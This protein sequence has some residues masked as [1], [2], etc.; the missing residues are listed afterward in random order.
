M[1][2]LAVLAVTAFAFPLAVQVVGMPRGLGALLPLVA[3]LGWR[4]GGRLLPRANS[5]DGGVRGWRAAADDPPGSASEAEELR[6]R[7]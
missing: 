5:A 7:I 6:E 1:T 4:A 3:A 2:L